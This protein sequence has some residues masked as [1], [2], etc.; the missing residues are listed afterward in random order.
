MALNL[1]QQGSADKLCYVEICL[2]RGAGPGPVLHWS[3]HLELVWNLANPGRAN[4]R[5]LPGSHVHLQSMVPSEII[6]TI[7][8]AVSYEGFM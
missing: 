3:Q 2:G 5:V 6:G 8:A 1:D 7:T 4:R